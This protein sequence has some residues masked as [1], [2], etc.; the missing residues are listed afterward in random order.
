[1][2][3]LVTGATGFIGS[4]LIPEL[5]AQGITVRAL[6]RN[7]ARYPAAN[8]VEVAQGDVLDRASL[9]GALQRV[10]AAYYFVH[11]MSKDTRGTGLSFEDA[12]DWRTNLSTRRASRA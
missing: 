1:M 9:A 7:A 11:S 8:G 5:L 10:D 4:H 6:T 3:V 2:R 12:T